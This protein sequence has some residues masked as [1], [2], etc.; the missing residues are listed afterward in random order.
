VI[1]KGLADAPA[2]AHLLISEIVQ[3]ARSARLVLV[4]DQ[5]EEI[6]AATG[7]DGA[8]ERTAFIEAVCAAATRP[9]GAGGEPPALVVIAVR[10]D[11]WDRCAAYPELVRA[12]QHDQVV[13]GPL[14]DADLRAR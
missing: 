11:Y 14:T 3:A 6:F 1:R 5:F 12:M 7:E 8:R 9:T 10:G 13:V 2:D 4:V